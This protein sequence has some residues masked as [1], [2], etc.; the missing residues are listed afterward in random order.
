MYKSY[1]NTDKTAHLC[2]NLIKTL[3]KLYIYVKI[4]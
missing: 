3:I 2:K 4:L 1:K